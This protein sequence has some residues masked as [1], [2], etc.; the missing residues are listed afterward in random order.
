[1]V[2][3]IS[4]TR[5]GPSHFASSGLAFHLFTQTYYPGLSGCTAT[6]NGM[7]W[8]RIPWILLDDRTEDRAR[9]YLFRAD[10]PNSFIAPT[11]PP[12]AS[13]LC[14]YNI[15]NGDNL[16]SVWG[17][18]LM[19]KSANRSTFVQGNRCSSTNFHK[20][21]LRKAFALSTLLND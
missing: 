9:T 7:V 18:V 5:E 10:S 21:C 16:M 20:V 12:L 6:S 3:I 2:S 8:C 1:M 14:P 19:A 13:T 4:K 17:F 11:M 15:S